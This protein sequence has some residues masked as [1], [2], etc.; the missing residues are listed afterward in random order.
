VDV[1]E[2]QTKGSAHLRERPE[3]RASQ[4]WRSW[5][6]AAQGDQDG[7]HV[8]LAEAVAGGLATAAVGS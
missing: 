4:R 5:P 7:V 1:N 2:K 8:E 3:L 6:V